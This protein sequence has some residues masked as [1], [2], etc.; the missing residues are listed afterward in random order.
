MQLIW[1]H[2]HIS[3]F[4]SRYSGRAVCLT[5]T[6]ED[7]FVKHWTERTCRLS[8]FDKHWI[9]V[10]YRLSTSIVTIEVE[11]SMPGLVTTDYVTAVREPGGPHVPG[12]HVMTTDRC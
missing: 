1:N 12:G 9:A 10:L 11:I 4:S 2:R 3:S 7:I 5:V 6:V 8:T